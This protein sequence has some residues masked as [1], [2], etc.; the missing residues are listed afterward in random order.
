MKQT[1]LKRKPLNVGNEKSQKSETVW[2]M[3]VGGL[4]WERF[5]EKM[6]FSPE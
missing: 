6:C 5:T 3:G 4:W 1:K 2:K